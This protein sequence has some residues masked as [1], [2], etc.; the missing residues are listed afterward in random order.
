MTIPSMVV[1]LAIVASLWRLSVLVPPG[2]S[3]VSYPVIACDTGIGPCMPST[4][5]TQRLG[6]YDWTFLGLQS[7]VKEGVLVP[8][9]H[10]WN[11]VTSAVFFPSYCGYGGRYLC[12]RDDV[13]FKEATCSV[14]SVGGRKGVGS[15]PSSGIHGNLGTG[16]IHL[17][18]YL[19]GWLQEIFNTSIL[20]HRKV[21]NCDWRLI[22][23][24]KKTNIHSL[25]KNQYSWLYLH[26]RIA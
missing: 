1:P 23:S 11:Q 17:L 6:D 12:P 24:I 7:R 15:I 25:R 20:Y 22:N 10:L 2:G 14:W 13:S 16:G 5:L 21:N 8:F 26:C 18:L 19:Q 3:T 4:G 9:F